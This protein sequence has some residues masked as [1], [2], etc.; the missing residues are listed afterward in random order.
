MKLW[1]RYLLK[2]LISNFA[3]M[4]FSVWILYAAIDFSVEGVR[5]PIK[6]G[7]SWA[8]VL[9]LYLNHFAQFADLFI[10]F[11]YLIASVKVLNDLNVHRELSALQ[12]GGLSL[13]KLLSPF[14]AFG[15]FLVLFCYGVHE[16]RTSMQTL[17]KPSRHE[18][19]F[20]VKL[21]DGTEL[22]YQK[23]FPKNQEL[24]DVFWFIS[25]QE[26][27]YMKYLDVSIQ[28]PLGKYV[29]LFLKNKQGVL[30]KKESWIS[31][32]FPNLPWDYDALLQ[33]TIP[34]ENRSLSFL[35]KQSLSQEAEIQ[36]HLHYKI[37]L[38]FIPIFL[39]FLIAP[40]AL[41]F[42][43]KNPFFALLAVS[44]FL[45]LVFRTLLD[46]MLILAENQVL[47]ALYAIWSPFILSFA[48]ALF[49]FSRF[50]YT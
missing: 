31:Y 9:S 50:R 1:K 39:F 3:W 40:F 21:S 7:T 32:S 29:D 37:A 46:A 43:R 33:Q 22:V 49:F 30:E 19:V 36:S 26:F 8:Q 48:A 34:P 12:T 25:P 14:A 47:S 28:T 23:Y 13:R 20:S 10:S 44:C 38:P 4:L 6:S 11:A 18:R 42:S 5:F 41:R 27:W 45:F 35:L 24:F 2:K 17:P 16:W 15:C